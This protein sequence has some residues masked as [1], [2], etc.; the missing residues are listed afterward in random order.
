MNQGN[1]QKEC[2][3]YKESLVL[4]HLGFQEE[5]LFYHFPDYQKKLGDGFVLVYGNEYIGKE[6]KNVATLVKE[7]ILRNTIG[8]PL[9]QQAFRWLGEK[10]KVECVSNSYDV[11]VNEEYAL[12][13][14]R[15]LIEM[16]EIKANKETI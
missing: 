10:Y 3:P 12:E 5:C 15:D 4:K 13:V 2:V 14:L 1:R 7:N 16:A 6:V 8:A 9:W 11:F